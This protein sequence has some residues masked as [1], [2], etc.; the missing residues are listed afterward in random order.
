MES[1]EA[2]LTR[3][4]HEVFLA[5]ELQIV[6]ILDQCLAHRLHPDFAMDR[7][8]RGT[9]TELVAELRVQ[10]PVLAQKVYP[11]AHPLPPPKQ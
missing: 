10:A 4:A 5:G 6:S 3:I 8:I 9:I 7:V 2:A 1:V 11:N